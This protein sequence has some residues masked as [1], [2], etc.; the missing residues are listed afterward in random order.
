MEL[1]E[2]QKNVYAEAYTLLGCL[3]QNDFDKIP[4]DII[5]AIEQN[6]NKVYAYEIDEDLELKNQKM[7]PETKA[8][9]FNILTKYVLSADEKKIVMNEQ[10]KNEHEIEMQK[11]KKYN[12]ENIFNKNNIT[13]DRSSG[14]N[15]NKPLPKEENKASVFKKILYKI[16]AIFK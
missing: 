16:K 15:D 8:L 13:E 5:K 1:S 2:K 9:I 3:E 12:P 10:I 6:R 11:I 4:K 14:Y 7:M